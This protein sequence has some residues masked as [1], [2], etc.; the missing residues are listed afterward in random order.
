MD[1]DDDDGEPPNTDPTQTSDLRTLSPQTRRTLQVRH[2]QRTF[3]LKKQ[4]QIRALEAQVQALEQ[5][6]AGISNNREPGLA[7]SEASH[8]ESTS[9]TTPMGV[10]RAAEPA[11]HMSSNSKYTRHLTSPLANP[12]ANNGFAPS[13][14]LQLPPSSRSHNHSYHPYSVSLSPVASGSRSQFHQIEQKRESSLTPA[15]TQSTQP[16]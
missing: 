15:Q 6:S 1:D 11:E 13:G 2:A 8:N 7:S 12:Q 4:E 10:P 3:W 14:P 9:T 16:G 5:L